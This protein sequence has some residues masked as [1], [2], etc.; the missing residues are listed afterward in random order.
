MRG[1]K[2]GGRGAGEVRGELSVIDDG[3]IIIQKLNG[4]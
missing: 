1:C 2:K 3:V 4:Q